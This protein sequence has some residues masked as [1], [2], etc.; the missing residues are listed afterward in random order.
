MQKLKL[1]K[2]EARSILRQ[3]QCLKKNREDS[4]DKQIAILEVLS[5]RKIPMTQD[6]IAFESEWKNHL[7]GDDH[8]PITKNTVKYMLPKLI[9][10]ELVEQIGKRY[11]ATVE[12]IEPLN[13]NNGLDKLYIREI[14]TD[15][16]KNIDKLTRLRGEYQRTN[17]MDR[18]G[19]IYI[20]IRQLNKLF[21]ELQN[22]VP[23][24]KQLAGV[25][26]SLN[27]L[28]HCWYSKI[29]TE[30]FQI[31]ENEAFQSFYEIFMRFQVQLFK[32]VSGDGQ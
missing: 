23:N 9:E 21:E 19:I 6:E 13:Q 24:K 14:I 3:S 15:I 2:D 31:I 5:D 26:G 11:L 7:N 12:L 27:N 28:K 10:A 29:H 22:F 1:T 20:K 17:D 4:I 8:K 18:A 16:K 25:I 30:K 32:E